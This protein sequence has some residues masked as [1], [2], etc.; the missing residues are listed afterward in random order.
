[1]ELK[2]LK[3][4]NIDIAGLADRLRVLRWEAG[5]NQSANV[6]HSL[7]F[8]LKR[9]RDLLAWCRSYKNYLV[10]PEIQDRPESTPEVIDLKDFETLPDQQNPEH[11]DIIRHVEFMIYESVNSQSS[12]L[13]NS[14]L[15]FDS[16]RYDVYEAKLL[17]LL[18]HI[19]ATNPIDAPEF[20]PSVPNVGGG[21]TGI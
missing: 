20:A 6:L 5:K 21:R 10:D 1:M 8:D 17:A 19:E 12:R 11:R 9:V 7:P 16:T 18:D 4:N 13:G 3:T 15:P 14:M 2:E